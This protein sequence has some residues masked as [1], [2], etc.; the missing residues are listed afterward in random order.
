MDGDTS[1]RPSGYS[2]KSGPR[3]RAPEKCV[4]SIEMTPS[5]CA[6]SSTLNVPRFNVSPREKTF[7]VGQRSFKALSSCGVI[8]Y[9]SSAYSTR[10]SV[11]VSHMPGYVSNPHS[12][13]RLLWPWNQDDLPSRNFI[14]Q[15]PCQETKVLRNFIDHP[16][17][18]QQI[19]LFSSAPCTKDAYP[20]PRRIFHQ[21]LP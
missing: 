14:F 21:T 17:L 13:N 15:Y 7:L 3:R 2:S 18:F 10:L 6:S 11:A 9:T 1:G 19:L 8:P 4:T 20:T 5:N 16:L 12:I